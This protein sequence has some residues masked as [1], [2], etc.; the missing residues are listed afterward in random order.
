MPIENVELQQAPEPPAGM[1][2]E[3]TA[4]GI[5]ESLNLLPPEEAAPP[6]ETGTTPPE[7]PAEVPPPEAPPAVEV[8]PAVESPP[9][10][11][12]PAPHT[13]RKEAKEAWAQ[14]PPIVREEMVKREDDIQKYVDQ[15]KNPAAIGRQIEQIV[16]P[17][18]EMFAKSGI[19]I[20][21]NYAATLQV[22]KTLLHGS[23]QEKLQVI[24]DIAR[25]SGITLEGGQLSA[26]PEAGQQYVAQLEARLAK[27]EGTTTQ[28][29][30]TVH[31]ARV[32]ELETGIL[33][34]M[35]DPA[36]PYAN[37]V[38]DD[39][40]NLISKGVAKN[41]VE[42]YQ[43]AVKANPVTYQKLLDTETTKRLAAR[44]ADEA[45][46]AAAAVKAAGA[47]VKSNG[48]RRAPPP[49]GSVDDTLKESLAN[50]RSREH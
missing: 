43:L 39:M 21:E 12:G 32:Q 2:M 46:R 25:S 11:I 47:N 19:N 30:S 34:F 38:A 10:E 1:D 7:V 4:D 14:V 6:A 45:T 24:S 13:W 44:D 5:A 49:A 8:A 15:V 9:V 23:P 27:L 28:V 31:E 41:L 29:A 35:Q 18:L 26:P 16:T 37:E 17:Y 20:F 36:H 42:A 3:A 22:Q 40:T 48:S 33:Q 50:I